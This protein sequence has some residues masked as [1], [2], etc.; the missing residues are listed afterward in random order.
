MNLAGLK[1][2]EI[3]PLSPVAEE[4]QLRRLEVEEFMT[5]RWAFAVERI[6]AN[7]AQLNH[8]IYGFQDYCIVAEAV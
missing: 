6:N 3:K 1:V 4:A 7:F 5:P 2:R 8:L